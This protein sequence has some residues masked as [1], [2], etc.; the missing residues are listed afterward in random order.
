MSSARYHGIL[1]IDKPAGWTSHDVV[2]RVRRLL[3]QREVGHAGTLDPLATGVLL[4]CVG[5][6]TRVAEYLL[7]STKVYRAVVRLGVVTDTYD[8]D[9]AVIATAPVPPLTAA[10]LQPVLAR[11]VGRISQVPP[12][13]SAIKQGGVA[14][15]RRARR[16][17]AVVLSPRWV[18]IHQL[19]LRDWQPPDLEL[20]VTCDAGTYMRSLAYDLG[21]ALGC[22]AMLHQLVRLRSGNF[23]LAE[24]ISL[25]ALA[26][27]AS[28]GQIA[29]CL[30]PLRAALEG[31]TPVSVGVA[32]AARLARG[33]PIACSSL[34]P[35]ATAY[36]LNEEGDVLA[37]L[38]HDPEHQLWWPR[39]VFSMALE[40]ST[41]T[42]SQRSTTG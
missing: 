22:G 36:A 29:R 18:T 13:Y 9:G 28:A 11:F 12:A 7:A 34:P 23:T 42:A 2:A 3:G 30:R 16:G 40:R 6:A 17:E 33:Q 20:E 10:D 39:K 21:R 24:A 15:H 14:A 5:Q 31:S 41:A 32:D 26:A 4:V 1:N 38:A 19:V 27:A 35:T 37:I 25:E 8:A